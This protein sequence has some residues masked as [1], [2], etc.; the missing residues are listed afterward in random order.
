MHTSDLVFYPRNYSLFEG[1]RLASNGRVGI[2]T[3]T[4]QRELDVYKGTGNDCTIVA[5]TRT[6]GAWFEANSEESTG[7]YGLKLRHGNTEKWFLGSYGSN[8]L[9]LKTATANASSLMEITPSGNVGIGTNIMDS[10]ADLSITND[11]SARIYLKS[12]NASDASISVSYTHLT[13]PTSG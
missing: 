10:S 8:N 6:A 9:Q 13:L 1:L 4:P 11:T 2:R 7:Y 5:R 12:G 3:D